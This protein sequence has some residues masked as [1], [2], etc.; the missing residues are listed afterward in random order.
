MNNIEKSYIMIKGSDFMKNKHLLS[1]GMAT[2]TDLVIILLPILVWDLIIFIILAGML[3]STVMTFLDKIIKYVIIISFCVTCPFITALFGKTLGQMVYDFRLLDNQGK[4]AKLFKRVLRELLGGVLFLG[5]IFILR[6][7]VLPIYLL[8]NFIVILVDKKGRGIADFISGTVPTYVNLEDDSDV[9]VNDKKKPT[10]IEEQKEEL[11]VPSKNK[12]AYHYDLH[13]QSKHSV[14]GVDTVEEL[15]QKAKD[16]GIKVLS[17]TDEYSVK[18]N[19]EAQV[20]SNPYGI[21]Y[22]PGISMTCLYKGHELKVLGYGI[23]YK[24]HLYIQLENEHLKQQRSASKDRI[25]KFKE[26]TGIDLNFSK[27]VNQTNSGIVTA[28]M[29]VKEALTNPLYEDVEVLKKYRESENAYDMLYA[30]YFLKDK[31]CYIQIEYPTLIEAIESIQT[32]NGLAVLAYPKNFIGD[33]IE[34]LKEIIGSGIDGIEIFS[35]YHNEED[36]KRYLEVAKEMNCFVSVGSGYCGNGEIG[37]TNA[38]D[39]YEKVIRVLIDRCLKMVEKK[40]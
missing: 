22:I 32:T 27:L 20:L 5:C 18:A 12:A 36:T 24:N 21:E 37:N 15:F 40:D 25:E 29:I 39:K 6:G 11:I 23:D 1:R 38:T 4:P 3:P 13:V 33:D 28:E 8:L 17:I 7:F 34:L 35:S 16:L 9:I 26:A 31:P 10:Q 2:L 14:G 30:D 19:I